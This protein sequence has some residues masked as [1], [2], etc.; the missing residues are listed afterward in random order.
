MNCI[1]L[2][3]LNNNGVAPDIRGMCPHMSGEL[4]IEEPPYCPHINGYGECLKC[5]Q[6]EVPGTDALTPQI[7]KHSRTEFADQFKLLRKTAGLSQRNIEETL[8][9]P[10][11][12]IRHWENNRHLPPEWAQR[13]ILDTMARMAEEAQKT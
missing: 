12:T 2:Y 1:E 5:W 4:D 10:L 8:G 13:M 11:T 6:R 7:E 3:K 9:I